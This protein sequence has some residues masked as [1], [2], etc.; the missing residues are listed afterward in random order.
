LWVFVFLVV[1]KNF[2]LS[3]KKQ[4]TKSSKRIGFL[5][6]PR[7]LIGIN[8]VN[9]NFWIPKLVVAKNF[10]LSLKKQK[11]KILKEDWVSML[12]KDTPLG[13]T[14]LIPLFQ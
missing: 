12:A 10:C 6:L 7:I 4:N 8:A 5:C 11:H 14:Q 1:A 9:P 13:S 3:L 2:C